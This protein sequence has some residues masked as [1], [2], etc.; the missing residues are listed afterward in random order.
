VIA[1]YLS[2]NTVFL[3]L[4]NSSGAII[5]FVY[6]MICLSQF[7]LRRRTPQSQLRVKMWGFPVLTL[8]TIA[9][10]VAVLVS[11]AFAPDSRSQLLL[12]LVSFAVVL[13]LYFALAR[14]DRAVPVEPSAAERRA[15][16]APHRVLIVANETVGAEELLSEVRRF[17]ATND[18]EFFVCVPANPV[19]T[20]QAEHNGAVYIWEAT[21][22]AALERLDATLAILRGE[23]LRA[24]GALGDYRPLVAMDEAVTRFHPDGIVISTHPVERSAWL[25]QDLV[26]RA[27]ERYD[28]PVDHVVSRVP[29][30][31][32]EI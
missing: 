22:R 31:A 3:F 27:V 25:R 12:S 29:A 23:G 24:E 4:L 18:A 2:P 19:D 16:A 6:L 17:G 10:I 21:Q 15:A 13:L 30:A 1:A 20:G 5:L 32:D 7:V 28:V 11:M 9:A 14:R 26:A 8:L